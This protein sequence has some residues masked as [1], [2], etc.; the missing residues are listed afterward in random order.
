[1]SIYFGLFVF[2]SKLFTCKWVQVRFHILSQH[3][4]CDLNR[5][6]AKQIDTYL[7]L[8]QLSKSLHSLLNLYVSLEGNGGY[9][10]ENEAEFYAYYVLL[11]LGH[12]GRFHAE[13]LSLWFPNVPSHVLGKAPMQ[14]A[15][16][17]LRFVRFLSF[18]YRGVVDSDFLCSCLITGFY[19][20][21]ADIDAA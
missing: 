13:P 16:K 1:M 11:N 2:W 15:R 5:K 12:H 3:E 6:S 9:H 18:P 14:L 4:L 8:Q 7:N 20:P 21:K 19:G 17:A 10:S